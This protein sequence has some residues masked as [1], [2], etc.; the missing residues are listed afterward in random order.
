[1]LLRADILQ[2]VA[3]AND[4]DIQREIQQIAGEFGVTESDGLDEL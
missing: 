1:M 3:V 4:P 2:L